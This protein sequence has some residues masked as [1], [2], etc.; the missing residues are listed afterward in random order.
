MKNKMTKAVTPART[1]LN[2]LTTSIANT[3]VPARFCDGSFP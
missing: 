1:G 3:G 2:L